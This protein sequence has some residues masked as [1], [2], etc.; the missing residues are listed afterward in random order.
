MTIEIKASP[1]E[2]KKARPVISQLLAQ[3]IS[4]KVVR[5]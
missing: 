2:L 4:L 1:K 3:G 5:A